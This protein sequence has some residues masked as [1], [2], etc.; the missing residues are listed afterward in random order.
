MAAAM[1]AEP[2]AA[3]AE[4]EAEAL[5]L[6]TGIGLSEAKARETLRNAALSAQLR[7]AV[8]QARGAL[9]PR[10]D[11]ATGALLYNAAARLRDPGRLAFLVAYIG[12]GDIR[13][14]LQL[15]GAGRMGG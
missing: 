14:D 12:R 15:G 2:A 10:L 4:A 6:F 13:S 8:L 9:G 5:G 3:E 1:A 11:K 7:R